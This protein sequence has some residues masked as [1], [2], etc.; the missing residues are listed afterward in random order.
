VF[1]AREAGSTR[2]CCASTGNA[3]SSLACQA[4][5][6]GIPATIFVPKHAPEPK[7][8]QL[9]VFGAQV[10]RVDAAY[11]RTWDLCAEVARTRPWFDRNCAVNPYLVEGKKTVALELAEQLGERM[12]DWVA[13]S[14]G[15]GCTIAGVVKGLEEAVEAG[16]IPRMPRVLGVQAAGAAPLV[17]AAETGTDWQPLDAHTLADSISV[18]T[19]RN[20]IKALQAVGRCG[21]A[22]VAVEDDAILEAMKT[23]ARCSG[24]FAEPAAAAVTAGVEVAARRGI[25]SPWE[26]VAII[27]SG[28]GLK[29][30]AS[31]LEAAGPPIDV[32]PDLDAV[33]EALGEA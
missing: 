31:A 2:V 7:L 27:V 1:L 18:G 4:A 3:A 29:D 25:V 19:P 17:R 33:E 20:P 9:R 8:A 22:W 26:S 21:G 10:F 13:L 28:N 30:T 32:A 5:S 16:F 23:T 6:V 24:V 12:P 11:D 15:D 14:V